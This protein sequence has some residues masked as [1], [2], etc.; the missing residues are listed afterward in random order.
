MTL[1]QKYYAMNAAINVFLTSQS[2]T[3]RLYK[4][5]AVVEEKKTYPYFQST[6]RLKEA[7]PFGTT[8][9]GSLTDFEYILNFF[10]AATSE[11]TNDASL[12]T[13]FEKVREAIANPTYLIWRNIA[14]VYGT[15][16]A[17][18]FSFKGGV[19]VLQRGLIFSCQ[20]VCSHVL[21]DVVGAEIPAAEAAADVSESLSYH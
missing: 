1:A 11:R 3:A 20:S 7:Q 18:E 14:N 21:A 17:P 8:E 10:T 12:F 5:G 19:E 6:Y 4:Y 16:Y 13:V 2:E 9:S 15:N